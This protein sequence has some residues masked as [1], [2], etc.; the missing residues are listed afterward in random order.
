MP[1]PPP[2]PTDNPDLWTLGRSAAFL[3]LAPRDLLVLLRTGALRYVRR[4]CRYR[5]HRAELDRYRGERRG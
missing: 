2:P 3:G 4:G 1:Q 5:I